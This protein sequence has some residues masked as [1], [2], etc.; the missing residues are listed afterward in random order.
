MRLTLPGLDTNHIEDFAMNESVQFLFCFLLLNFLC[1]V[2]GYLVNVKHQPNPFYFVRINVLDVKSLLRNSYRRNTSDFLRINL[3]SSGLI[4]LF[5]VVEVDPTVASHITAVISLWGFVYLTYVF[6]I[7]FFFQRTPMITADVSFMAVGLTL[8]KNRKYLILLAVLA[9]SAICYYLFFHI[10]GYLLSLRASNI[11]YFILFGAVA[12]LG[13]KNIFGFPFHTY[14]FR[15][16]ISPT[17]HFFKNLINSSKYRDQLKLEESDVLSKNIYSNYKLHDKPDIVIISIESFGSIAYKDLEVFNAIKSLLIHFEENFSGKGI[18]IASTNSIAPQAGGGSWLSVGSIVYGYKMENDVTYDALFQ[19]GSGFRGYKSMLHYFK[20]QGYHSSMIATLGG[21]EEQHVDW[22]K[23]R[24][25]YPMDTFITWDDI[26]Y[27]GKMLNFMNLPYS[28]PDQYSLW[29]GMEIINSKTAQPKIS[30]FT[31]LNSHC[32]WHSPLTIVNDYK[33]LNT[34]KTF[35]TTT[36]T[37]K[38]KKTNYISA[39]SYQLEVVFDYIVK[40]PDKVYV[41][42]G[43]HQPPFITPDSLGFETPLYVLSTSQEL[44]EGFRQEG[45]DGGLVNLSN[46]IRHEGFYSLFMKSF[47]KV[48]SNATGEFP[49]LPNGIIFD[50]KEK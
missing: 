18:H 10:T 9:V 20:D 33:E 25:A 48:Y 39:I 32:N 35:E 17:I 23:V 11:F 27:T 42:F 36:Q 12:L 28:P 16:V 34:I 24:N 38:P 4:L 19:T 26:Q 41:I 44:I 2:L 50:S 45:F 7:T 46:T 1:F 6:I 3:D 43:D 5:K 30:L 21:F 47:L 49:T 31:T 8:A 13:G 37:R 22:E 29:K 15:T 14:H 40:N